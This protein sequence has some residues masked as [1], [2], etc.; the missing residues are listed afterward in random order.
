MNVANLGVLL[1]NL[2]LRAMMSELACS[3]GGGSGSSGSS[4]GGRASERSSA[5]MPVPS[6][7]SDLQSHELI[8]PP[9]HAA[10]GY[11]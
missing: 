10:E 7:G 6:G 8:C 2:G 11:A 9:V 3:F 1:P 4:A 5:G